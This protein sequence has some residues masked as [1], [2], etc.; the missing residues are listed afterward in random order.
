MFDHAQILGVENICSPLILVD[1]QI[2]SGTG[3]LHH[4]IFPAAGM[5]TGTSVGISSCKEIAQQTS[6][7]I[8]DTHC[9]VDKTLNLHFRRNLLPDSLDLYQ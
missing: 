1:R 6:A 7:G 5:C 3:L 4:R 9:P 8:R 2:F